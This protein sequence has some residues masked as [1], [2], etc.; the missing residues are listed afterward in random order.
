MTRLIL[1]L[2]LVPSIAYADPRFHET[3][4]IEA[5]VTTVSSPTVTTQGTI[6]DTGGMTIASPI[7]TM[8]EEFG[9]FQDSGLHQVEFIRKDF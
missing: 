6:E 3:L 8:T 4:R 5:V 9:P 7:I 1:T 2:C